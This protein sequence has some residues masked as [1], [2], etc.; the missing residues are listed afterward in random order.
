MSASECIIRVGDRIQFLYTD[1]GIRR[2]VVDGVSDSHVR[3][4]DET[5]NNAYR[6]FRR[7]QMTMMPC[8]T[9]V[10]TT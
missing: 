1:H 4:R 3:I 7:Q 10:P 8:G 6:S 9:N 5:R 2:G